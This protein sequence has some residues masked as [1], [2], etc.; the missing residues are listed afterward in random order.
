MK[1]KDGAFEAE[2]KDNGQEVVMRI[3]FWGKE[4][5]TEES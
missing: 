4:V 5:I 1:I 3:F 2:R